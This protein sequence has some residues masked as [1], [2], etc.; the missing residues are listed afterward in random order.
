MFYHTSAVT[1]SLVLSFRKEKTSP[2]AE[3]TT[4]ETP[5]KAAVSFKED[6]DV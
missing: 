5:E 2:S 4:S 3:E 1:F 6:E